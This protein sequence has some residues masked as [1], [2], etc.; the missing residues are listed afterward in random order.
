MRERAVFA[1]IE[2]IQSHP[3]S[4]HRELSWTDVQLLKPEL[5]FRE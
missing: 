3:S 5:L 1:C 4:L 2:E